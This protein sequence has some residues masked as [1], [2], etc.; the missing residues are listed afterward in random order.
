MYINEHADGK[1]ELL[2]T[3]VRNGYFGYCTLSSEIMRKRRPNT[4]K[5]TKMYICDN[6]LSGGLYRHSGGMP[7]MIMC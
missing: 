4:R 7:K 1:T 2:D 5:C 6:V 3:K